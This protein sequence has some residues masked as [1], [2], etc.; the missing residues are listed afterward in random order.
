[1]RR[2]CVPR[3]RSR[4]RTS[5]CWARAACTHQARPRPR[6]GIMLVRVDAE[7]GGRGMFVLV[8][9]VPWVYVRNTT[10]T[11]KKEL[12][13][14]WQSRSQH[15]SLSSKPWSLSHLSPHSSLGRR[16][17]TCPSRHPSSFPRPSHVRLAVALLPPWPTAPLRAAFE[18][19]P[20]HAHGLLPLGVGLP[21]FRGFGSL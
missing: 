4:S 18:Q 16:S 1:M 8:V 5:G 3:N 6:E 17:W 20:L 9:V 2:R 15:L 10:R 12:T 7:E 14:L 11:L 21:P 13:Y 19:V